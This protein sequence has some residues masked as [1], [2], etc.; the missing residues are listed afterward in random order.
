MHHVSR[1]QS[2]V[3][4]PQS[5]LFA[6]VLLGAALR[7][8]RYDALSLWLDEGI[9]VYVTRMPWD[10]VLGFHGAYET[11]PPLYFILVKLATLVVPEVNAG[12]LVSI[13]AGTLTI[14]VLYALVARMTTRWAGVVA[15]LVL[16]ISP[17]HI[18]F[19]QEARMYS[20]TLLLITTSYLAL[21]GFNR[22]PRWSWAALYGAS[23]LVAMYVNYGSLYALLPQVLLLALYLKTHGRAALKLWVAGLVA[24]IVYLP[25][26][27]H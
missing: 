4:S 11:H 12:R 16:T 10:T 6:L 27:P 14:P 20:L 21:A 15:A 13:V 7:F 23:V 19:S 8:Y 2:S 17:L 5:L 24:A 1:T 9:T 25:W 22:A 18:W 26:D 3:L